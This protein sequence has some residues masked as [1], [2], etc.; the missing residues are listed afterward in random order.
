MFE[1]ALNTHTIRHALTDTAD[2][3]DVFKRV[4][5]I[6][7]QSVVLSALP[8]FEDAHLRR[9]LDDAELPVV[10]LHV[11]SHIVRND[12]EQL[13]RRMN[14]FGCSL[15]TYSWPAD[16]DWLDVESIRRLI[17]DLRATSDILQSCGRS[18]AIRHHAFELARHGD[19]TVLDHILEACP[20]LLVEPST[21]WLALCGCSTVR[22]LQRHAN[23]VPILLLQ[24]LRGNEHN[25][26]TFED[27]GEGNLNFGPIIAAAREIG[28][29]VLAVEKDEHLGDTL[30][31]AHRSFQRLSD[32]TAA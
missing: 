23:R 6:G 22:F 30:S 15:A 20:A 29:R 2:A 11:P 18:L 17:R 4:A 32:W 19:A 13:L 8:G 28:C 26:A 27:L 5:A 21:Y 3:A 9:L 24:D 31:S 10:N 12:P 25:Q 16:V 14:T 1:L 7:Y